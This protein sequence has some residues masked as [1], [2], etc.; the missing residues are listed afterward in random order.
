MQLFQRCY[1]TQIT[2]RILQFFLRFSWILIPWTLNN[3]SLPQTRTFLAS[4]PGDFLNNFTVDNS[5]LQFPLKAWVV[6]IYVYDVW[7][8][9][10]SFYYSFCLLLVETIRSMV[11]QLET[12]ISSMEEEKRHIEGTQD[13]H[14]LC[15]ISPLKKNLCRKL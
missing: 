6:R 7:I 8:L 15:V 13:G 12:G 2:G 5:N 14:K 10:Y 11:Q 3:P 9:S 4:P 1:K